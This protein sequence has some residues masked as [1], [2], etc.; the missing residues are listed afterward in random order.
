MED[1]MSNAT[2]VNF[3]FPNSKIVYV[4]RNGNRFYSEIAAVKSDRKIARDNYY[5]DIMSKRNWIQRLFNIK[6]D[7]S[8]Y[9]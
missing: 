5:N 8:L 7:M 4:D 3:V 1:F 6:P 9:E 2:K